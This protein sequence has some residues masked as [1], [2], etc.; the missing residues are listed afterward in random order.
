MRALI[1]G[2]GIAGPLTGMAL[3]RA[4]IEAT[5]F[6]RHGP[7]ELAG[8]AWL[9]IAVNGLDALRTLGLH[10]QVMAAGF[11]TPDL[12]IYSGAGKALGTIPLGGTLRDG[13]VTH[14]IKRADLHQ[15]L[16]REAARRGVCIELN[17]KLASAECAPDG[18]Q[19][20]FEDGT[21]AMG[22]L[23]IGADGL[24]SRVRRLIDPR[25]PAPRHGGL[26]NLGGFTTNT[27]VQLPPGEMRMIFG[28]QCFF[29]Y[30]RH[31]SGEVWW[32]A[33]PPS[34]A[35]Q[36]RTQLA[37]ASNEAW[38]ERLITMLSVDD[39]P[40][41]DLVRATEQLVLAGDHYS[42][43]SVPRWHRERM[44]IVGDAAHAA[45]PASGQGAS[46]AAEDALELARCLRDAPNVPAAFATFEQLRR[47]RVERVVAEGNRRG[48]GKAPGPVGRV[49]RDL[50]MPI[51]FGH[52]SKKG[53]LSKWVHEHHI[54]F[55]QPVIPA[56]AST[57]SA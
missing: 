18:V 7:D 25:A 35:E 48:T 8:G 57:R 40:A 12:S 43:A 23:L 27:Q 49:F 1:V 21:Q 41:V 24:H 51:V 55:E 11:P 38:R 2:G 17:K 44:V 5:V 14:S 15:L 31:P 30:A 34:K 56:V 50:M 54:A 28:R 42:L 32:F 4:G 9:T 33:N 46:M 20:W 13:T 39:S 16:R 47:R 26:G 53:D 10:Q 19:V 22:D 52:L 37:D 36:T 6:E 45:S 29:G 3:Q